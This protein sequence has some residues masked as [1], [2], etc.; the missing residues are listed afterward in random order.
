MVEQHMANRTSWEEK[1]S[2]SINQQFA[3]TC[4]KRM[5]IY[6]VQKSYSHYLYEITTKFHVYVYQTEEISSVDRYNGTLCNEMKFTS[7]GISALGVPQFM[8]AK[9]S[10]HHSKIVI[11]QNKG[12]PFSFPLSLYS[13][14]LLKVILFRTPS[15]LMVLASNYGSLF[16]GNQSFPLDRILMWPIS[17]F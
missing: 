4:T 2:Q 8:D 5:K 15:I 7:L 6:S 10:G 1:N 14:Y 12:V 3:Y 16:Y 17:M 9:I 11:F 13:H